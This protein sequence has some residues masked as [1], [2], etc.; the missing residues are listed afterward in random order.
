MYVNNLPY[1]AASLHNDSQTTNES[2]TNCSEVKN[3]FVAQRDANYL[4]THLVHEGNVQINDH[5]N[6]DGIY[7]QAIDQSKE[8]K[9]YLQPMGQGDVNSYYLQLTDNEI[10]YLQATS[11]EPTKHLGLSVINNNLF[12][13]DANNVSVS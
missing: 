11:L 12:T 9:E 7:L 3:N 1:N 2:E 5:G 10:N 13:I 8:N 6:E 4:Y